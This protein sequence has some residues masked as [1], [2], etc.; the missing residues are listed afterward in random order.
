MYHV[1]FKFNLFMYLNLKPF[2]M[3]S[4]RFSISNRYRVLGIYERDLI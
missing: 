1:H 2:Y 3:I 4:A